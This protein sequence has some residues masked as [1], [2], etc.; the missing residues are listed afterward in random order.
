M[1]N[2]SNTR[3]FVSLFR[4]M[5]I[6][7]R[8]FPQRNIH[9]EFIPPKYRK[10]VAEDFHLDDSRLINTVRYIMPEYLEQTAGPFWFLDSY[11]SFVGGRKPINQS[12]KRLSGS[13]LDY[14]FNTLGG[15]KIL[16]NFT[17]EKKVT[18]LIVTISLCLVIFWIVFLEFFMLDKYS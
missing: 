3:E 12:W 4:M 9:E 7:E 6:Q 2:I 5:Q 16:E 15:Y 18:C 14:K 11:I 8:N 13:D 1:N 17:I 10:T